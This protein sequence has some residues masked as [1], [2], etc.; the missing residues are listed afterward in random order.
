L[1]ALA[2][3]IFHSSHAYRK[4]TRA[5]AAVSR[6]DALNDVLERIENGDPALTTEECVTLHALCKPATSVQPTNSL[7]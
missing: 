5:V 7:D 1:H 3:H 6:D 2:S 4:L